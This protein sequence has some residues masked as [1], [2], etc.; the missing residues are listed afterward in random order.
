MDHQN[1]F[2]LARL[3]IMLDLLRDELFEEL[4][5]SKGSQAHIILRTIQNKPF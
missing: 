4:L 5:K 3:I 2:K 1:E